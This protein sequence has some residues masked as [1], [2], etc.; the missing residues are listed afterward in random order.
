MKT[1]GLIGGTT[2]HSTVDYYRLINQRVS[3]RLG[4]LHSAR[5]ILHS[6]NFHE[7]FTDNQTNGWEST[8]RY[9]SAIAQ[10]LEA[11]GAEG[12]ILCANTPHMV[13]PAVRDAIGIPLIHIVEATAR[14][15]AKR[16][17]TRVGL[18]GT[19][20]TMEQPFY[21]DILAQHGIDILVP[22]KPVRDWI[23]STVVDEF[24][25]GI[26]KDETRQEYLRIMAE[27]KSRGAQGVV[28]GCTEIP[29]LVNPSECPIPAYDT[30]DIHVTAAV[31]WMLN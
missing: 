16:Q 20:F 21:R 17:Q 7:F 31:E 4:G 18:L 9:L 1:L 22:E 5:L 29:M 30:T 8:G 27:L 13:A 15:I 23:H 14:E 3:Q 10:R 28:L 25:K 11:A 26:F 12:L 19:V 2:W 24:G 6:M